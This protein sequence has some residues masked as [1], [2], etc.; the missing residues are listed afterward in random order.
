MA[1]NCHSKIAFA[2]FKNISG[3]APIVLVLAILHGSDL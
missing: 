3:E 1:F 2:M